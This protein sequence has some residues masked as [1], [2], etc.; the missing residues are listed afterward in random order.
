MQAL[1]EGVALRMAEVVASMEA[2][3]PLA[4][5]V[6]IDGGMAANASFCRF[7]AACLGRTII[8]SEEP[9]LTAAGTAAL[10]AEA[11][12]HPFAFERRGRRIDPAPLPDGIRER[13]AAARAAVQAFGGS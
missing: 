6:S 4:D 12:G 1:L 11:A 3:L 9:E 10:A 7:L 8:V 2:H 13:F 5:P